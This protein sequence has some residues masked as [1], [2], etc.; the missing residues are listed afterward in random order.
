MVLDIGTFTYNKFIYVFLE[1]LSNS[2]V[3]PNLAIMVTEKFYMQDI[4][5]DFLNSKRG[6]LTYF[7]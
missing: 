2:R 6:M 1:A 5:K 7:T 4:R 3:M